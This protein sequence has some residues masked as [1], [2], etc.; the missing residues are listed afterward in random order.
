[1]IERNRS[2][3]NGR[4]DTSP[5]IGAG[6]KSE[7]RISR[8]FA[9][10]KSTE[11]RSDGV[12]AWKL[13]SRSSRSEAQRNGGP[14][15]LAT[16][17]R[18]LDGSHMG[19]HKGSAINEPQTLTRS[20][21]RGV[22]GRDGNGRL[23]SGLQEASAS[24]AFSDKTFGRRNFGGGESGFARDLNGRGHR[25]DSRFGDFRGSRDGFHRKN[26]H[27]FDGRW[28]YWSPFRHFRGNGWGCY[29]YDGCWN[30]FPRCYTAAA[31]VF[32]SSVLW[33]DSGIGYNYCDSWFVYPRSYYNMC[34]AQDFYFFVD[35]GSY[36]DRD[37]P[38][39]VTE[40]QQRYESDPVDVFDAQDPLS[41]AY[42]AFARQ[43]YYQSIVEFTQAIANS[44]D[45]GLI[46]LARAQA[47]IATADYHSAYDDICA[48]MRLIPDWP[49]VVFN[50][51]ELY[52]NP[53]AFAGQLKT[54]EQWVE[55]HPKDAITHF[56]LGYVYYFLQ[57]YDRAK[58][59][60]VNILSEEPDH[61]Q[62][63]LLLKAIYERETT[64]KAKE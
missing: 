59:E 52:G 48:G 7:T 64:A 18:G 53:D 42:S 43:K 2:G 62:A 60:F 36:E 19:F 38:S 40:T 45:D 11:T 12:R 3:G 57:D 54:L 32:D 31:S 29:F 34:R 14:E 55:S 35:L 24:R 20:D 39:Y 1:M 61:P 22:K 51:A 25:N 17:E 56:V 46:R 21:V 23:D 16:A 13:F 58:A 8:N 27:D 5:E 30:Q 4:F 49:Q 33:C 37:V 50:M 9:S 26:F 41:L 6:G 15:L 47:Y 44:P 63:T 10:P 28:R